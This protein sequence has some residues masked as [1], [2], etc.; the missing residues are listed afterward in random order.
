MQR[1]VQVQLLHPHLEN[2][3]EVL[4][5]RLF[6]WAALKVKMA[7]IF[8]HSVIIIFG[9]NYIFVFL[10]LT[11]NKQMFHILIVGLFFL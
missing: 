2:I 3:E 4:D 6:L 7:Q 10:F 11:N 8:F 1:S 5:M 9:K